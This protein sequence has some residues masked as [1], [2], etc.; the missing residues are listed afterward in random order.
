[1]R[2][3]SIDKAVFH[4]QEALRIQP[5]YR[6]ADNNLKR[7]LALK[8]VIDN[9]VLKIRQALKNNSES[10]DFCDRLNESRQELDKAITYYQ[11][12]LS[13]QPGYAK[14]SLSIDNYPPVAEIRKDRI[15]LYCTSP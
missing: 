7:T 8:A 10:P 2:K 11:N 5:D 3:G 9:A 12:V 6:D 1:M 15:Y 13:P 4:F 14:E